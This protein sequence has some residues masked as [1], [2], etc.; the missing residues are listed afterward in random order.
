MDAPAI[1]SAPNVT[2]GETVHEHAQPARWRKRA[3]VARALS[4]DAGSWLY[5]WVWRPM[6]AIQFLNYLH[7]AYRFVKDPVY[8]SAGVAAD[9]MLRENHIG[10]WVALKSQPDF[11]LLS[12]H[13]SM[14]VVWIGAMMLQKQL[15]A[16]MAGALASPGQ[17]RDYARYRRVHAAVGWTLVS[18]GVVG[19]VIGPIITVMNHG[20]E[21]MKQFLVGQPL[22][23]LPLMTMVVVSARRRDWSV[24]THR[25]WAETAFLGPALSALWAEA[26]IYVFG[27]L[28]PIG[29]RWGELVASA[30]AAVLGVVFVV[31]PAWIERS[32]GL[33]ADARALTPAQAP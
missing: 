8:S 10:N 13:L 26:M 5:R 11:F 9:P 30:L 16:L 7:A 14:A 32:R 6:L 20:N 23:F 19:I 2:V 25:F 15:V 29:P 3:Q 27:R 28:T 24:R 4:D 22:F 1:D 18:L 33:A 17:G 31:V 21:P 12:V